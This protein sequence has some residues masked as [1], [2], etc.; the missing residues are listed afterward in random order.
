[1]GLELNNNIPVNTPKFDSMV[2]KPA[3]SPKVEGQD[4]VELTHAPTKASPPNN[5]NRSSESTTNPTKVSDVLNDQEQ[6]MLKMLFPPEGLKWG[7]S[8]YDASSVA[9][10][11]N[12]KGSKL[13]VTT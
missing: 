7:V 8:A 5:V 11:T 2:R 12:S 13:D 1:M 9:Q 10:E 3:A 4:Q 6:T